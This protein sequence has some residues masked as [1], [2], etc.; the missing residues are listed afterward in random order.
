MVQQAAVAAWAACIPLCRLLAAETHR[1]CRENENRNRGRRG[2]R[3]SA[4]VW[5]LGP[6]WTSLA[7]INQ[8]VPMEVREALMSC[9]ADDDVESVWIRLVLC[10]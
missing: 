1:A 6:I 10:C 4:S 7:C 2:C 8:V 9:L 5:V 3:L